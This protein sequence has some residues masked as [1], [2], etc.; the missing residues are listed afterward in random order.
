MKWISRPGAVL[1]GPDMAAIVSELDADH[2]NIE[3]ALETRAAQARGT[4]SAKSTRPLFSFW[5]G[6]GRP[7]AQI[8]WLTR[9]LDTDPP[10]SATHARV[11][12]AR[13]DG[14]A[15]TGT[16]RRRRP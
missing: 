7:T 8:G 10:P 2:D 3:G 5:I 6:I 11:L 13:G 9:Y 16:A 1:D 4:R 12:Y 14:V 15:A